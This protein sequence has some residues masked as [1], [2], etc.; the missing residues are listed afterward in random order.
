MTN[1]RHPNEHEPATFIKEWR[2]ALCVT[3]EQLAERIGRHH[4]HIL[5]SEKKKRGATLV[6]VVEFADG[7]QIPWQL[8]L[9]PPPKNLKQLVTQLSPAQVDLLVRMITDLIENP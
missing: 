8:L 9:R 1:S 7:L 5:N 2:D 4:T 3:Q 6:K